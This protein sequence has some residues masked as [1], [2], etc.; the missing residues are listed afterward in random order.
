[1]AVV[2][3]VVQVQSLPGDL[4][5]ATVSA[6]PTPC[7]THTHTK[8]DIVLI[9]P[10]TTCGMALLWQGVTSEC[11]ADLTVMKASSQVLAVPSCRHAC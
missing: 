7:H 10:I 5:P 8:D 9:L 2:I 1:M 3:A 6:T 11:P 4:P